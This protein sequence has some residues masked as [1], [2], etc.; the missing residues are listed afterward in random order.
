MRQLPSGGKEVI[1]KRRLCSKT[2]ELGLNDKGQMRY[3]L[4]LRRRPLHY[5]KDG[6]LV[7]CDLTPRMD[8]GDYV[9]D[10]AP[11]TNRIKAG[12]PAYRCT[13]PR[14]TVGVE[15]IEV[16]G[17]PVSL[18]QASQVDGVL[19]WYDVAPDTDYKIRP[20]ADGIT[21]LCVLKS[22]A[23]SRTW[24]WQVLGEK[25][26]IRAITGR[27][28]NGHHCEIT[29]EYVG[30]KLIA[31]WTGRVTSKK[32]LR[33]PAKATYTT[34]VTYPVHIDPTVNETIAAGADDCGSTYGGTGVFNNTG[35]G[36][37]AGFYNS[38][39]EI[40]G[41]RFQTIAVPNAASISTALLGFQVITG[42]GSPV[43]RVY[44]DDVDDAPA[45]S[46][47]DRIRNL[48]KTAAYVVV[49]AST[50]PITA[51]VQEIVDRTGWTSSNDMRFGF[52]DQLGTGAND[53]LFAALEHTA[54]PEAALEIIYTGGGGGPVSGARR[55]IMI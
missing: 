6:K 26:L 52:F 30:D 50:L 35:T 22:P 33:N 27:D 17:Q 42:Y 47:G 25:A 12:S 9:V 4:S 31:T 1:A 13:T 19:C 48:T 37:W 8:R 41:V 21:T 32:R 36:F 18:S 16:G 34:D 39:S 15:L 54:A 20:T 38:Y 40:G 53:L 43:L 3:R 5:M 45:F 55:I 14:G 24:T 10:G 51:I 7:D 2:F 11:V 49:A 28:A 46:A 29:T 23:A 44:G